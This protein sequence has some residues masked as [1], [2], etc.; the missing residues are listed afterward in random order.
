MTCWYKRIETWSRRSKFPHSLSFEWLVDTKELKHIILWGHWIRASLNDL[1]IQKNWN[2]IILLNSLIVFLTLNDLLI[3]KNW[4]AHGSHCRNIPLIALND[5]LIQK[6]WNKRFPRFR[7]RLRS[8]N[9][10]LIQKNWNLIMTS[11]VS[12]SRYSLND[13][14]IQKNWNLHIF[15]YCHIILILWMTCWYKRIETSVTY[16]ISPVLTNLWMTCW[17]KR[18]ET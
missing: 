12:G 11:L 6:N 2:A 16:V 13:L 7:S 1:L 4:N 10:L 18:I 5:L 3:Q 14:L 17:Y 15:I 9:D 8:L